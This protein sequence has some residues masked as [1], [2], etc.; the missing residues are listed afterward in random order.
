MAICSGAMTFQ[1]TLPQNPNIG[2]KEGKIQYFDDSFSKKTKKQ[3]TQKIA[4]RTRQLLY[5]RWMA[6][7]KS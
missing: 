1:V 2:S 4:C 7:K 3:K 5:Y 6:E